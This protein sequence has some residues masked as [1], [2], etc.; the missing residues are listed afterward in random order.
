MATCTHPNFLLRIFKGSVP[1]QFLYYLRLT[2]L[3]GFTLSYAISTYVMLKEEK[4]K[5]KLGTCS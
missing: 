4:G 1:I 3:P 5:H 2:N